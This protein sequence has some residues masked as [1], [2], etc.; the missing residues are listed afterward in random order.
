MTALPSP[1]RYELKNRILAPLMLLPLL[2]LLS[3]CPSPGGTVATDPS[4]TNPGTTGP[5]ATGPGATASG[6]GP[7]LTVSGTITGQKV[8]IDS[9]TV[10]IRNGETSLETKV[11]IP[12]DTQVATYSISGVMPGTY[13][14]VVTLK[15]LGSWSPG[16]F[17][18]SFTVNNGDALS[19]SLSPGHDV[20]EEILTFGDISIRDSITADLAIGPPTS[21]KAHK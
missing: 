20:T 11:A 16:S 18:Y 2:N 12:T 19:P 14:V 21:T 8:S 15:C 7:V 13:D 6:A 5:V 17:N 3:G 9:A 10:S 1:R 4:A